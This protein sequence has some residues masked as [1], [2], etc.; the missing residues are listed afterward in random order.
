M[1]HNEDSAA[2]IAKSFEM[3]EVP[4]FQVWRTLTPSSDIFDAITWANFTPANPAAATD[5]LEA[6]NIH[7]W[8][9][10]CQ[11]KQFNLQILLSGFTGQISTGKA[12]IRSGLQDALT[13]VPS[14]A[15]GANKA[16]GWV[17]VQAV[18][19]RNCNRLEK[20][21]STGI[22]TTASPATLVIEGKLS[23]LDVITIMEW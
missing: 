22:G 18:I 1:P 15:A 8:L 23:V 20:L 11:G 16:G 7:N 17:N 4:A 9:L 14:G 12:N 19:Q 3:L 10:A 6:A 2:F 5:S 21:F 13:N